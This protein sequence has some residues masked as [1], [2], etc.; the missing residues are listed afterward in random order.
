IALNIDVFRNKA[1]VEFAKNR[2][3]S[4]VEGI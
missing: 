3:N 4:R 2:L 1:I